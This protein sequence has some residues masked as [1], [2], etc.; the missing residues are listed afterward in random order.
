MEPVEDA[1]DDRGEDEARRGDQGEAGIEGVEAGEVFG[2]PLTRTD[3]GPMPTGCR[4]IEEGIE[5]CPLSS[6]SR[7]SR[8]ERSGDE[9]RTENINPSRWMNTPRGDRL[10]LCSK[11]EPHGDRPPSGRRIACPAVEDQAPDVG[12]AESKAAPVSSD[13]GG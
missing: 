2:R 10:A 7:P 9:R 5:P 3:T 12:P 6:G 1:V 8:R 4:R 11:R 13:R